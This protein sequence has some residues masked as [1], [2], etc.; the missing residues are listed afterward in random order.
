MTNQIEKSKSSTTIQAGIEQTA[1]NH[2]YHAVESDQDKYYRARNGYM[3]PGPDETAA[4]ARQRALEEMAEIAQTP[5]NLIEVFMFANG[6]PFKESDWDKLRRLSSERDFKKKPLVIA[7]ECLD[8]LRHLDLPKTEWQQLLSA[9][10][11]G[12][13]VFSATPHDVKL[14]A[15]F[16]LLNEK[17]KE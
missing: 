1:S 12:K 2:D 7:Q 5:E 6:L 9:A 8:T 14:V 17:A 4:L 3:N 13:I 10:S 16:E 11:T 15:L